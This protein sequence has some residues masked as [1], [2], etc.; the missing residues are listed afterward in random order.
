MSQKVH[1]RR[2]HV[3]GEL[4]EASGNLVR[5]CSHCGKSLAPF[6]YFDESKVMGIV[7]EPRQTQDSKLPLREYP[8]LWG[9]TAYWE[10]ANEN[11]NESGA[12]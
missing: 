12:R 11:N 7:V 4:N 10:S 6:F 9:L 1:Y 2:C 5:Q 8:P 3:C